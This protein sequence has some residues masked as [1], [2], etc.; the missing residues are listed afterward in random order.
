MAATYNDGSVLYGSRQLTLSSAGAVIADNIDVA[1]PTN[2]IERTNY[3]NE[4]SGWVAVPN[5]VTG[6]ATLQ[7]SST[8]PVLGETFTT[9]FGASS[10]EFVIVDI[11]QP[12]EKGSMKMVNITFRKKIN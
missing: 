9:T 12:E 11:T 3:V 8:V 4:P 1:R 7:L 6:S 10:E 2:I 5:F